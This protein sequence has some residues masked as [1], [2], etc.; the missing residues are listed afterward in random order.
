VIPRM[1]GT[2]TAR[3]REEELARMLGEASVYVCALGNGEGFVCVARSEA[4]ARA[5][6]REERPTFAA[7]A[8]SARK[9]EDGE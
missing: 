2:K 7:G 4:F 6:L 3:Q 1:W 9:L 5:V 8:F